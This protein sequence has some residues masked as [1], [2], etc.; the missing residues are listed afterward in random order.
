MNPQSSQEL[1]D[2][3]GAMLK[4]DPQSRQWQNVVSFIL[5]CYACRVTNYDFDA[6]MESLS[7]LTDAEQHA[8]I[9]SI[10]RHDARRAEGDKR[11]A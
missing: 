4:L 9:A 5:S 2:L 1:N 3:I 7:R 11:A 10:L 6:A 8:L